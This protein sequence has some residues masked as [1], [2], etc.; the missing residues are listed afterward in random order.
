[1]ETNVER[2][3]SLVEEVAKSVGR[4][5]CKM[6]GEGCEETRERRYVPRYAVDCRAKDNSEQKGWR[7]VCERAG[8]V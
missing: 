8:K 7:K 6:K 3:Q 2:S 5:G 4:P 1:M